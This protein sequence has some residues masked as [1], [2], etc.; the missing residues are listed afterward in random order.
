M[1]LVQ[2]SLVYAVFEKNSAG[3]ITK[4]Q[5]NEIVLQHDKKNINTTLK[6]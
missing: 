4:I 1:Q 5:Q 3:H 2:T 6:Q